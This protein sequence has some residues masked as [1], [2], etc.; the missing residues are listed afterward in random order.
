MTHYPHSE[1]ARLGLCDSKDDLD[2]S[3][4]SLD[5]TLLHAQEKDSESMQ[6]SNK[7][8][9]EELNSSFIVF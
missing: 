2:Y 7:Q 3:S 4:I 1:V 5:N 8:E 6:L 9:S